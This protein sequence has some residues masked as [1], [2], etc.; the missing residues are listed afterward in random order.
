MV[1]LRKRAI[2][3]QNV[4]LPRLTAT[5]TLPKTIRETGKVEVS[6]HYNDCFQL[7][8]FIVPILILMVGE[9]AFVLVN[10]KELRRMTILNFVNFEI[11]L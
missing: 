8:F 2:L 9:N 3:Y 7:R 11:F 6:T 5:S 4:T 1:R 10:L